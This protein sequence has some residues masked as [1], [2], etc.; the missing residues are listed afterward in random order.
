MVE[1]PILTLLE[2]LRIGYPAKSRRSPVRNALEG[3]RRYALLGTNGAFDEKS[4][5]EAHPGA[6]KPRDIF[7]Y[8]L[9]VIFRRGEHYS[10]L[11]QNFDDEGREKR[12][13]GNR[14][15]ERHKTTEKQ[16]EQRSGKGR[17]ETANG[18]R[19]EWSKK[20]RK[21]G[22]RVKQRCRQLRGQVKKKAA[23]DSGVAPSLVA[24]SL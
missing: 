12:G 22:V 14:Q 13:D 7:A 18:R 23:R 10:T 9:Y 1:V 3:A 19:N 5:N 17:M 16:V 11:F 15:R 4:Q 6:D 21:D 2:P 20:R 24:E 8:Y